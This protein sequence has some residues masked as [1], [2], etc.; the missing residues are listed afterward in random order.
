MTPLHFVVDLAPVAKGR[1]R[2]R[3]VKAKGRTFVS[4]YTPPE[5]R[6]WEATVA[7]YGR[8]AMAGREPITGPVELLTVFLLPVPASWPDWKRRLALEG[9]VVPTT[10][11]DWDNLGKAAADALN[12]IAWVDDS[13]V[14]DCFTRKRYAA[15]PCAVVYAK[16]LDLLPAQVS[17][18]PTA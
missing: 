3:V 8:A 4:H 5:T 13:Q 14:V 1:A 2:S 11:P 17:R 9:Q 16:P 10:K 15:L 7:R 18:R 6:A 12:G